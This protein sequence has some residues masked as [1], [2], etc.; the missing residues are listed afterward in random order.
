MTNPAT[1]RGAD[2]IAAVRAGDEAIKAVW[3]EWPLPRNEGGWV[4]LAVRDAFWGR[5]EQAHATRAE[6]ASQCW[7]YFTDRGNYTGPGEATAEELAGWLLLQRRTWT[8]PT[9]PNM[10]RPLTVPQEVNGGGA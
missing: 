9:T 1:G 3:A 10:D 6:A 7:G 8:A 2:L 4:D 5:L